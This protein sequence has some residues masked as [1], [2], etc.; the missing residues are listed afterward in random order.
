MKT[1]IIS[2]PKITVVDGDYRRIERM[3]M[4]EPYMP[5]DLEDPESPVYGEVKVELIKGRRF[6]RM[7]NGQVETWLI[8]FDKRTCESFEIL[9]TREYEELE[10]LRSETKR[11][12]EEIHKYLGRIEAGHKAT[13]WTKL[14]WLFSTPSF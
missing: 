7:T 2:D 4:E 12:R 8:G 13:L 1:V 9:P 6:S 14:K 11:Q 5:V 10:S 3:A